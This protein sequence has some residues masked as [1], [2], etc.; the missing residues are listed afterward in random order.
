LT[1]LRYEFGVLIFWDTVYSINT[2]R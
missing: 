2:K 1:K